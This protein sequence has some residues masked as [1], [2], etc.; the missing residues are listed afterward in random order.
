MVINKKLAE[1]PQLRYVLVANKEKR[2]VETEWT[3]KPKTAE[4]IKSWLEKGGNYGVLCGH[5]GVCVI[6]CDTKELED[7]IQNKLP[8]TFKVR[9]G[10]GGAHYYYFCYDIDKKIVIQKNGKHY[11][12]LQSTGTQVV[13]P[14]S[15]HPNGNEYTPENDFNIASITREELEAAIIEYMQPEEQCKAIREYEPNKE[16]ISGIK[17]T[18]I[19]N[20][21]RFTQRKKELYGSNPWHGSNG[22]QNFWI[23]TE[24]NVA[25]CFRC[26]TP[27]TPGK[28]IALN[29]GIIKNCNEEVDNQKFLEVIKTAKEKYGLKDKSTLPEGVLSITNFEENTKAFIEK[30]PFFYDKTQKFWIWD[31]KEYKWKLCDETDM[32][33]AID[34]SLKLSG[35]TSQGHIKS[36]YLE[37]FKKQG[38]LNIPKK[39]PD[40]WIQFKDKIVDIET[41][42]TKDAT[43]EYLL[44]NSIPWKIGDTDK[45]PNMDRIFEQW[46]G[47]EYA[48]TLHQIIAYC[49]L[50]SYPIH[51]VFCFYGNGLNGKGRFLALLKKF[52]GQENVT[53]SDLDILLGSRF[54]T[55]KLHK[56]LVCE[57]GETNFSVMNKTSVLK[58]LTGQDTISFE[59]KKGA[60]FD[61]YNYAKILIATNNIPA[62]TDKTDG[63]YRRWMIIDFSKQFS[64]KKDILTEIPDSEYEALAFKSVCTIR[65]LLCN[66]EF[67]NE[68]TIDDRRKV[69]EDKSNPF[70]KFFN[71]MVADDI[72]GN[73]QKT[74]FREEFT[75]W[76][77]ENRYRVV[78]DKSINEFMRD[79]G[80]ETGRSGTNDWFKGDGKDNRYRCWVGIK[81][82]A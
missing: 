52:I 42:E 6:D 47:T 14:G 35:S 2:P 15:I 68:G 27:I 74:E 37:E 41:G 77:K 78:G 39:V 50:P 17:L 34:N 38:R 59:Y 66:R 30:S 81:W 51:R 22:G 24:K 82:K 64:E 25:Y 9:T 80:I 72:N 23:N 67:H 10:S 29:E 36:T 71:E 21:E 12:E 26:R 56:K 28:A 31:N 69:F 19:I 54:E 79:R 49:M 45:T 3:N 60:L 55:T 53:S 5:Q 73:I 46:V 7:K 18:N 13:A 20:T 58:K 40:T 16:G 44:C 61:D 4:E 75:S 11:G 8:P 62:T 43:P 63:F 33:N 48:K 76:C 57:M 65:E 32:M 1:Y 70:E